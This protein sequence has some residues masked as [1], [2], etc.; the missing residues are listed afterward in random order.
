MGQRSACAPIAGKVRLGESLIQR[1]RRS[2]SSV[3]HCIDWTPIMRL[4]QNV[5]VTIYFDA[6]ENDCMCRCGVVAGGGPYPRTRTFPIA[7]RR[8]T[9]IRFSHGRYAHICILVRLP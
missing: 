5:W 7:R 8:G 3:L 4:K 2:F 1:E 6:P 9:L